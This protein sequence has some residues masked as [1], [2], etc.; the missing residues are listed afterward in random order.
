[1]PEPSER[2]PLLEDGPRESSALPSLRAALRTLAAHQQQLTSEHITDL[3]SSFPSLPPSRQYAFF[4]AVV[5]Y[6]EARVMADRTSTL[7]QV[8]GVARTTHALCTELWASYVEVALAEV[9]DDDHATERAIMEMLWMPVRVDD[10][11][12][13]DD[14]EG[15]TSG[16]HVCSFHD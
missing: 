12:E 5:L 6:L 10:D 2:T 3:L 11:G 4:F 13:N 14:A 8:N 1:M 9:G 15:R 16:E 7:T